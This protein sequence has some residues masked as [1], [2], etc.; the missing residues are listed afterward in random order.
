ME[1]WLINFAANGAVTGRGISVVNLNNKTLTLTSTDDDAYTETYNT[2][3]Y[4]RFAVEKNTNYVFSWLQDVDVKPRVMIFRETSPTSISW[5]ESGNVM[6]DGGTKDSVTGRYYLV[7]N[8]GNYGYLDVR[9]GMKGTDTIGKT[10]VF[11]DAKLEKGTS[12]TSKTYTTDD[13]ILD[14]A[15]NHTLYAQW[16]GSA[17][18]VTFNP[19]GGSCSTTSKTVYY[20]SLYGELPVAS[21]SNYFFLGWSKNFFNPDLITSKTD[22]CTRNGEIFTFDTGSS[23]TG[24]L[25]FEVQGYKNG[26]YASSIIGGAATKIG[27]A[28][29]RE[30]V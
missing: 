28:S 10:I 27:R 9:F 18:T 21:K 8:T 29:C 7:I 12:V 1:N 15:S 22:T 24:S 13:S 19:N 14:P 3:N 25:W 23:N 2:D 17:K 5:A 20:N 4:C 11:S 30:R 26:S 16:T 6:F